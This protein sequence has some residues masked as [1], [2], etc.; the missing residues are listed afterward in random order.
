MRTSRSTSISWLRSR[1][2]LGGVALCLM[3]TLGGGLAYLVPDRARAATITVATCTESAL[4]AAVAAAS[5]G[6]T[7]H[8]GCSGTITLTSTLVIMSDL[9]LDG[10]GQN[11]TLSGGHA[12]QVL[13]VA[14]GVT[15]TLN[16]L[17]VANG[18]AAGSDGNGG[19]GRGGGLYTFGAT[20]SLSNCI[21]SGNT[22]QGGRGSNGGDNPGSYGG[23]GGDGGDAQGGGLY[24]GG[25]TLTITNCR[26]SGNAARGGTAGNGGNGSNG[27][28]GG[29]AGSGFGGSFYVTETALTLTNSSYIGNIAQG[30]T[31]GSGGNGV[32]GGGYG[33]FGGGGWGGGGDYSTSVS[34]ALSVANS[35]FSGNVARGGPGG[36]GGTGDPAHSGGGGVGGEGGIAYGGG[37]F[38]A[39]S[40]TSVSVSSTFVDT[41]FSGN[42][43]QGGQWRRC[44][45]RWHG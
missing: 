28:H 12:V 13:S 41:T 26:F 9:T 42:L 37:L 29:N 17:T 23:P 18:L 33:A 3:L 10:T 35:T 31:G 14:S 25:G 38:S 39:T 5:S 6:D 20:L 16:H 43:A 44:G 40:P 34:V 30:G 45:L 21:F 4:D 1:W 27:G 36:N 32:Y 19:V 22:A 15:F 8:F 24:S 2:V 7:I 11:V